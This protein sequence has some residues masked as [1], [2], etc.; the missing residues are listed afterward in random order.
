[1]KSREELLRE[2]GGDRQRWADYAV[3]LRSQRRRR[4]QRVAPRIEGPTPRDA[5]VGFVFIGVHS[6]LS[7]SLLTSAPT[8]WL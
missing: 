4:G 5:Y 6:W 8:G 1:M 3:A 2:L 7:Q